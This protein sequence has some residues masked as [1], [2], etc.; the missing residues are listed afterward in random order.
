M[1]NE[2]TK[3]RARIRVRQGMLCLLH[4]TRDSDWDTEHLS[5]SLTTQNCLSPSWTKKGQSKF[6]ILEH[7]YSNLQQRALGLGIRRWYHAGPC[8]ARGHKDLSESPHFLYSRKQLSVCLRDLPRV[9]KGRFKQLLIR[10]GSGCETRG[11]QSR[12]VLGQGPVSLSTDKHSN[13]FE[14]FTGTETPSRWEHLWLM[15]VRCPEACRPQT[16]WTWRL[17]ML[18][19]TYL[20]TNPSEECPRADHALFEQLL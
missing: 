14:L 15:T 11:K 6:N 5:N 3:V 19:P 16:S 13:I 2:E 9:P 17:K 1:T 10:E 7:G 4:P 20:T 12:E 18:T 8:G